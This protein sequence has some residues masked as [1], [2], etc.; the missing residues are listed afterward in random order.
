MAS[1]PETDYCMLST[2]QQSAR[3]AKVTVFGGQ[4]HSL[5]VKP[6]ASSLFLYC[7]LG[8]IP[9]NA[10]IDWNLLIDTCTDE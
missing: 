2:G 10:L 7:H 6:V 3:L 9:S 8:N 1:T 4:G 5:R